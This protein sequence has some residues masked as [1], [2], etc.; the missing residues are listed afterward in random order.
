[1]KKI[2]CN[3]YATLACWFFAYVQVTCSSEWIIKLV[4]NSL[5][6][7]PKRPDVLLDCRLHSWGNIL[8]SDKHFALFF[9]LYIVNKILDNSDLTWYYFCQ[10]MSQIVDVTTNK[11]FFCGLAICYLYGFSVI[12]LSFMTVSLGAR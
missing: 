3:Y 4:V 7:Q 12:I 9:M 1:M 5:Y 11:L 2:Q 10:R 6:L 8:H